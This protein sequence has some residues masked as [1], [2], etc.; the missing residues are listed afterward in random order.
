MQAALSRGV[1]HSSALARLSTLALL[2]RM[3]AAL[4]AALADA[5]AAAAIG[6]ELAAAD[7]A[8]AAAARRSGFGVEVASC[9]DVGEG[10]ASV[11]RAGGSDGGDASTV[12]GPQPSCFM[13]ADE[14][15]DPGTGIMVEDG[16]LGTAAERDTG[17][18]PVGLAG[19]D[20]MDLDEPGV[21]GRNVDSNS[22]GSPA[23][24]GAAPP[25]R[26]QGGG[27]SWHAFAARLR[28]AARARL[29]DPQARSL[30]PSRHC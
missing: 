9:G 8:A 16:G 23:A 28:G 1:Q 27:A 14:L 2:Q 3:L 15:G 18:G 22:I 21:L 24:G 11:V 25:G 5:D 7:A 10:P 20:V 26:L 29:P 17:S 6:E 4:Q 19:A 30:Q 13:Q 12:G